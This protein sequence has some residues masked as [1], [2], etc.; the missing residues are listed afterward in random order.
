MIRNYYL[1]CW[2]QWKWFFIILCLSFMR[3]LLRCCYRRCFLW[4]SRLIWCIPEN[5]RL[6]SGISGRIA[7]ELVDL[8]ASL[9]AILSRNTYWLTNSGSKTINFINTKI[10]HRHIFL[11]WR[12][13]FFT[14][15][16]SRWGIRLW[17]RNLQFF[18]HW[19]LRILI[20][21]KTSRCAWLWLLQDLCF[22]PTNGHLR[23][24]LQIRL[25]ANAKRSI[26]MQTLLRRFSLSALQ[27]A[28]V[29]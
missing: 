18:S 7:C 19:N 10:N 2:L 24:W 20:V 23:L 14:L 6:L 27:R 9:I 5:G 3:W 15:I 12:P 21:R 22:S 26:L 11:P 4:K 16:G 29:L 28:L 13:R 1:M 17:N 8:N 25:I